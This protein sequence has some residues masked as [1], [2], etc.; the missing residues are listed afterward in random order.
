MDLGEIELGNYDS[1]G[2]ESG[3]VVGF[4][5]TVMNLRIPLR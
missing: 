5:N 3:S 1:P 2:S 4:V